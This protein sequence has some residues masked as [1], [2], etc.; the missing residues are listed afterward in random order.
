[1]TGSETLTTAQ[2]DMLQTAAQAAGV[3]LEGLP[4]IDDPPTP[5]DVIVVEPW[6]ETIT[7]T[8]E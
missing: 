5:D 2:A 6:H 1:V 8:R 7:G 3:E 4:P